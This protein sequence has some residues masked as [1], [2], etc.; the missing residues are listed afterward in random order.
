MSGSCTISFMETPVSACLRIAALVSGLHV[1][2]PRRRT[3]RGVLMSWLTAWPG[4]SGNA[5]AGA[6]GPKPKVIEHVA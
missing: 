6:A 4:L 3:Q 1:A 5:P 2:G